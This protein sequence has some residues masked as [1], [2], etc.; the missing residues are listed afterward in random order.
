MA[1]VSNEYEL[2]TGTN[3]KNY[4]IKLRE[5]RK[6]HSL[7]VGVNARKIVKKY[8]MF[9]KTRTVKSMKFSEEQR[10]I[11]KTKKRRVEVQ[12][13]PG[14]GKTS[15]L[16][17]RIDYL[18]RKGEQ[19]NDLLA[20]T[21]SNQ[22]AAVLKAKLPDKVNVQ[23]FHA[24]GLNCIKRHFR[25]LG[26]KAEPVLMSD[27]QVGEL[28]KKALK[29]ALKTALK[30][31]GRATQKDQSE[32]G[33]SL[34]EFVQQTLASASDIRLLARLLM[35]MEASGE[36]VRVLAG[37]HSTFQQFAAYHRTLKEVRDVYR[38]LKRKR[39]FLDYGDM[40]ALGIKTVKK[41]KRLRFQHLFVDEYQ[42]CNALQVQ[43]LAALARKIPNL[44]T[45]GDPWQAIFRFI[46]GQYTSLDAVLDGVTKRSLTHSFRLTQATADLAH[47]IV[48]GSGTS[49]NPLIGLRGLGQRAQ[50]FKMDTLSAGMQAVVEIVTNLL[51]REVRPEQIAILGRTGAQL[52]E[53]E[54]A[55]RAVSIATGRRHRLEG[56][57][58]VYQVVRMV[59]R[60]EKIAKS[61][62]PATM[63]RDVV[64]AAAAAREIPATTLDKSI[65][66]YRRI[67]E[68]KQ[69]SLLSRYALC[70]A[71]YVRLHGG[72]TKLG[73]DRLAD[74]NRW[75]AACAKFD[76]AK[77]FRR[78]LECMEDS[79]KVVTSTIHGAKGGEWEHVL[80]VGVTDGVLPFWKSVNEEQLEEERRLLYVAV[81]RAK[82]QVYLF[83]TPYTDVK[84]RT[85]YAELSPFITKKII[86]KHLATVRMQR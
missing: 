34:Q 74:L 86:R 15:T 5:F 48:N 53:V 65:R 62:K 39:G 12:A 46:G 37:R 68:R 1:N 35:L 64:R 50:L 22:A 36:S 75:E 4:P 79:G 60:L 30:K 18:L 61:G 7:K 45:F 54:Q 9:T 44:M 6:F 78:H 20:L 40:I 67:A 49:V 69:A 42:D 23:T 57:D 31:E 71:V 73:K 2:T 81:T 21:F 27:R 70:K 3:C 16:T 41:D 58:D 85:R 66:D 52:Y 43:M 38:T 77:A 32:A 10:R 13:C 76:C 47:A 56:A 14:A 55:L 25:K 84:T 17:G 80:V 51:K 19:A 82:Q 72:R 33:R 8:L 83:N 63:P 26:F 29:K 11:I 28:L 24:F 59:R